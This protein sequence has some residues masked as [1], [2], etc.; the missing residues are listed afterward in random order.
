MIS[1]DKYLEFIEK[2]KEDFSYH[3]IVP[4][5]LLSSPIV[6]LTGCNGS[7]KSQT[8]KRLDKEWKEKYEVL[9]YRTSKEGR[10]ENY[11][12]PWNSDS[13]SY[14]RGL[15]SCFE[16]EGERMQDLFSLWA[17]QVLLPKLCK[18]RDPIRVLIDEADS[19][20]SWDKVM[21][22]LSGISR[23]IVPMELEKGRD[24]KFIFTANSYP[25]IEALDSPNTKVL[26]VPTK[27]EW[28]PK[29]YEE[30][31][32]PYKYYFENKYE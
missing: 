29:T 10:S 28:A 26:W 17:D 6:I 15:A 2:K 8:L 7:G 22:S 31:K 23:T 13:N 19:G 12:N 18:T 21:Y 25:M 20:L 9:F 27:E 16:S 1:Y 14:A 24:I 3:I 30:F 32:E 4:E 5:S 11:V